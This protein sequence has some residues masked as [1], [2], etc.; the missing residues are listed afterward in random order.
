MRSFQDDKFAVTFRKM[1]TQMT[2]I[3]IDCTD[4][5][6]F[7]V[8]TRIGINTPKVP[9]MGQFLLTPFTFLQIFLPKQK[10]LKRIVPLRGLYGCSNLWTENKNVKHRPDRNGISRF[11]IGNIVDSGTSGVLKTKYLLLKIF[12]LPTSN[13]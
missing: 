3:G 13:F 8:I 11:F 1:G 5:D 4:F 10:Y 9:S 2:R 7:V 6:L 12:Q